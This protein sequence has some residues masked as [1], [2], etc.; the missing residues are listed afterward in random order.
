MTSTHWP[1][2][3]EESYYFMSTFIELLIYSRHC[4]TCWK[5]INKTWFFRQGSARCYFL[6]RKQLSW[7]SLSLIPCI[8]VIELGLFSLFYLFLHCYPTCTKLIIFWIQNSKIK[9]VIHTVKLSLST[10]VSWPQASFPSFFLEK[11][12]LVFISC[13]DLTLKNS[14]NTRFRSIWTET[15][16]STHTMAWFFFVFLLLLISYLYKLLSIT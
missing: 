12:P 4:V 13:G 9:R 10:L 5:K 2:L 15:L 14:M 11:Q 6:A 8:C 1:F 7:Q 3:G 16:I